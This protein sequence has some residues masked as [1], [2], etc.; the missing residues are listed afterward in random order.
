MAESI[1]GQQGMV[2]LTHIDFEGRSPSKEVP[3]PSAAS[4]QS[5]KDKLRMAKAVY[6]YQ[7][8]HA[9]ELSFQVLN[10]AIIHKACACLPMLLSRPAYISSILAAC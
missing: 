7:S 6:T 9:D 2:P 8:Q 4:P 5:S 10:K 1:D 3:G